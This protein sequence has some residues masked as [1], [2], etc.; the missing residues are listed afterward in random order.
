MSHPLFRKVIPAL[1][2][3]VALVAVSV[4]VYALTG[5]APE[6]KLGI[7]LYPETILPGDPVFVT[8]HATS[9]PVEVFVDGQIV[10]IFLYQ[11]VPHALYAV[12]FNEKVLAHEV[13]VV[14]ESGEVREVPFTITPRAKIERPIGIPEKLGGNTP[15][16]S[17]NLVNN[18]ARENAEIARVTSSVTQLWE[19]A[20]VLPLTN[21]FVT[22]DYGYDRATVGQTIVHKGTDFRAATGTPVVAMNAGKVVLAK[23]F[24]VYGNT[25]I[26]DHGLG[27]HTLYMHL[28]H[29]DVKV[30]DT[31]VRGQLLGQS[32]VTGYANAP[33]LH[34]SLKVGGV[35]IDPM[36]FVGFW[37]EV[38]H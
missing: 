28:S 1:S 18:L 15:V 6:Q 8:I 7:F 17:K 19:D 21:I 32:G 35:S 30:G 16:A 3:V 33:H 26:V 36:V 14:F 27:V 25:V 34:V 11:G 13:K 24:T 4:A 5:N 2:I 20:F 22:D 12:D 37:E 23:E 31:V 38:D 9:T 29:L 10:P